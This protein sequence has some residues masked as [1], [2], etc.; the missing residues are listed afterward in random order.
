[1]TSVPYFT[2]E[3][4]YLGPL[5]L[6]ELIAMSLVNPEGDVRWLVSGGHNIRR[7]ARDAMNA[8]ARA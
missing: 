6:I 7:P 8:A 1:V 5:T 2:V 4:S 3:R